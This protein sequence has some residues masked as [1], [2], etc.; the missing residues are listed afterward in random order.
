MQR[1]LFLPT[2]L[3]FSVFALLG[4]GGRPETVAEEPRDPQ[5]ILDRLFT[6][7]HRFLETLSV[8]DP[9]LRELLR[10]DPRGPYVL[11]RALEARGLEASARRAYRFAEQR[12]GAPWDS[13]SAVRLAGMAAQHQRWSEAE[14]AAQLA[15]ESLP[16]FV[17]GWWWLGT[18]LYEQGNME[19]LLA[20]TEALPMEN[21]AELSETVT[22]TGLHREAALWRAVASWELD[23]DG[24]AAFLSAFVEPP[25]NAIHRRLYLYLFYRPGAL[26][27]LAPT[28]QIVLEAVYRSEGQEH[29]EALRLF[30]MLEPAFL[31][32]LTAR[33]GVGLWDTIE[34]SVASADLAG[35]DGW[36]DRLRGTAAELPSGGG[37]STVARMDLIGATAAARRGDMDGAAGHLINAAGIYGTA[38][39]AT[40]IDR[41]LELAVSQQRPLPAVVERLATMGADETQFARAVDRLLPVLVRDRDWASVVAA[42]RV[43]PVDADTARAHLRTVVLAADRAGLHSAPQGLDEDH[44]IT[45][46]RPFTDYF[47]AA[48]RVLTDATVEGLVSSDQTSPTAEGTLAFDLAAALLAAGREGSALSVAMT[49]AREPAWADQALAVARDMAAAG[50]TSAALDLARRAV[51]RSGRFPGQQELAMLY[52]AAF[53]G[54]IEAA[55]VRFDVVPR[56]VAALVREESHFRSGV[57]SPVGAQGL[58][59]LM[60]ATA[61]EIRQR[62][63]WPE[64][65]ADRPADNLAMGAF[66]LNYLAGQIESPILR[67][68]AYNAGLGRGR[69]WQADFGDLPMLLQIE[70]LP[71]VET[72]WYLRRIAVS[73]AVYAQQYDRTEAL[74]A[75]REFLEGE[76]W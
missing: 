70:A 73:Q 40:A 3:T 36:I 34:E 63:A 45:A 75:F 30:Q 33:H 17:D 65:D 7:D 15:T 21:N 25:V 24:E 71:F 51:A 27:R 1:R 42:Y 10:I 29:V 2:L 39:Q 31:L 19:E 56:V 64:A 49:A 9:V 47:G 62:M 59:Q 76:V 11:G 37:A 61:A 55:A 5:I 32:E 74:S 68:A 67:L 54:E 53:A 38:W 18:A 26:Q 8:E 52:P 22:V 48:A 43:V 41:W 60:P 50:H 66:Y 35:I 12:G 13:F 14:R 20:L 28:T 16:S 44:R 6:G 58:A 69:R 4:C 57:R 46:E 72:R 23:H